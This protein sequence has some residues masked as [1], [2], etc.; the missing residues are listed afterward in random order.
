MSLPQRPGPYVLTLLLLLLALC[1][2]A[3]YY[4]LNRTEKQ[5]S[6]PPQ[7]KPTAQAAELPPVSE[8]SR[9]A[10]VAEVQIDPANL[11]QAER[12]NR[13]DGTAAEDLQIVDR[14]IDIYFRATGTALTGENADIIA[15]LTGTQ[16]PGQ[17]AR[18]FPPVHPSIRQGQLVDRW[19]TPYW[20][21]ANGGRRLEIRSA[22]P[23]KALF[24]ADDV[25]RHPSPA[26]LGAS[27][28]AESGI[29]GE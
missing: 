21:H 3:L 1:T 19:G 13:E 16:A 14:F 22:G 7:K 29:K 11:R 9:S 28:A 27:P 5:Q 4:L 10:P 23:D 12:L 25:V 17:K 8:P 2:G 20:F 18:V 26:G 6:V 24:T 15:A